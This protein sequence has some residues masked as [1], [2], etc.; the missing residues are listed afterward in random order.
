MRRRVGLAAQMS[1]LTATTVATLVTCALIGT[2]P[3]ACGGDK[4]QSGLTSK[5]WPAPPEPGQQ[6][7]HTPGAQGSTAPSAQTSP[8]SGPAQ[9][10]PFKLESAH[11]VAVD[12]KGT[13]YVTDG[14]QVLTLAA[15][16][17]TVGGFK[18]LDVKG[19]DGVAVDGASTIY[20]TDKSG[21]KVL[22]ITPDG[23]PTPVSAGL[24]SPTAVAVDNSSGAVYVADSA[25]NKVSMLPPNA[26]SF[27]ELPFPSL[28]EPVGVAVDNN[29]NVYV[30]DKGAK[31]LWKLPP[32]GDPQSSQPLLPAPS[33]DNSPSAPTAVAVDSGGAVYFVDDSKRV[34][35]LGLGGSRSSLVQLTF[36]DLQNP[37]GIAVDAKGAVYVD[38][39]DRVLKLPPS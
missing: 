19:L 2:L 18:G 8:T 27:S 9:Q 7:P 29:G 28:K 12:T 1:R 13:V 37:T 32:S 14:T 26:P 36:K 30:A 16:S 35:K 38:D 24:N 39:R 34:W 5:T 22:R 11:G 31:Q 23:N 20:V 6:A 33:R 4:G 10:L 3:A 25:T 21:H 15:N 17:N